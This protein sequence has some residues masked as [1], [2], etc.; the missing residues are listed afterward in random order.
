GLYVLVVNE[1]WSPWRLARLA[2]AASVVYAAVVVWGAWLYRGPPSHRTFLTLWLGGDALGGV[3]GLGFNVS[4]FAQY[5]CA[6]LPLMGVA[7]LDGHA[8]W[9]VWVARFAL[10][11]SPFAIVATSQRTGLAVCLVEIL[12]LLIGAVVWWRRERREGRRRRLVA[13]AVTL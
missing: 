11:V 9:A 13:A 6:Y 10:L 12:A 3:Q 1:R 4:D 7:L 8:R 2:A 5:A